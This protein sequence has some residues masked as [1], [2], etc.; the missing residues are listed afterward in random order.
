MAEVF[1]E[2]DFVFAGDDDTHYRA[3]ACGGPMD[4]GLW[5]GWI[6][7]VPLDPLGGGE[8]LRSPRETTQPNRTDAAYWAGGLSAIYLE[9][10][11]ERALHPV[12]ARVAAPPAAPTYDGPAPSLEPAV[13]T[14]VPPSILDPFS[15]YQKG[16]DLLRG[17]LGALS[18]WHLVNILLAHGLSAEDPAVLRQLG[19]ATLIELIVAGVR[20]QLV[21]ARP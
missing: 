5:Q 1:A 7:F 13:A 6:E 19:S 12:V 17:Q 9:G 21:P 10:A 16:E 3:R 14:A 20:R 15:V 4:D 2:F 18:S 8:V 11:F